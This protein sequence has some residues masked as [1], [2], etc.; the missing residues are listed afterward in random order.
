MR[1]SLE[2]ICGRVADTGDLT[3]P[4]RVL[5]THQKT[6]QSMILREFLSRWCSENSKT[7]VRDQITHLLI[8]EES[9]PYPENSQKSRF[10]SGNDQLQ[11]GAPTVQSE[12]AKDKEIHGRLTSRT[13]AV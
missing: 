6:N 3:K 11:Q 7:S 8:H 10:E 4:I 9:A 13:A 5:E 12:N 2:L 1:I